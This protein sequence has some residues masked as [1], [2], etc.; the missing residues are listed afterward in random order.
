L[1]AELA[2]RVSISFT[3]HPNGLRLKY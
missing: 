1:V 3:E 2:G